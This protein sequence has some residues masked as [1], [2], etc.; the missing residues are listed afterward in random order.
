M[1]LKKLLQLVIIVNSMTDEQLNE[2]MEELKVEIA[3][4]KP[5]VLGE[6]LN[7]KLEAMLILQRLFE[8]GRL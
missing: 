4:I 3:E 1:S 2:R 5:L 7:L 6:D 8:E